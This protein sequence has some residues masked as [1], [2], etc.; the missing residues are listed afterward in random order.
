MVIN[1]QEHYRIK[2]TKETEK[3]IAKAKE[4][5]KLLRKEANETKR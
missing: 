3:K 4:K 5:Q 2:V 1:T